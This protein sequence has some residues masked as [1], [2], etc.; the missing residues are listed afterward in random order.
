MYKAIVKNN[1]HS[2]AEQKSFEVAI[3]KDQIYLDEE[4]FRWDIV[5][6]NAD[7]FHIIKDNI[8]Y[9]AEILEVDNET[10]SFT[11]KINSVKLQVQLM[12]KFDLL[13]DQLGMTQIGSTKINDIKA[14]MPG[15]VL[16]IQIKEG[17]QVQK[18]DPILILEAMKMEN[19]L[20][21]PGEGTVKN[22]KVKKGESVEKNQVLILF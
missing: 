10:K 11:L 5:E 2:Q 17:D 9:R 1:D 14:P 20:K 15:L 18:G 4:A 12:D 16:E 3:D 8:S 13:L 6:T 19:I 21:S 7:Y 22:I